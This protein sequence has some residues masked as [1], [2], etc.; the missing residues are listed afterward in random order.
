MYSPGRSGCGLPGPTDTGSRQIAIATRE[1]TSV[2]RQR[3]SPQQNSRPI[4]NSFSFIGGD[5]HGPTWGGAH[6]LAARRFLPSV[7]MDTTKDAAP[8]APLPLHISGADAHQ[9]DVERHH[10]TRP[11]RNQKCDRQSFFRHMDG[12][13][14]AVPSP[15]RVSFQH[16]RSSGR[17][18]MCRTLPH[19]HGQI[20]AACS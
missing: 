18:F 19:P 11:R 4:R 14:V 2:Q 1:P 13:S 6:Q 3:L 15:C 8:D 12:W 5:L 10:C 20:I 16:G 7:S 17:R 9:P